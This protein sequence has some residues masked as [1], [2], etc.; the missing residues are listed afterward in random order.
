MGRH[1]VPHGGAPVVAIPTTAGT[2]SEMTKVAII[3]DEANDVK[4]MMFDVHLLPAVALVDYELTLS[5][6]PALT[7]AVGVD[8]L[9]HGIEALVSR[10]AEPSDRPVGA[11]VPRSGQ[12]DLQPV[13]GIR[14]SNF[15]LQCDRPGDRGGVRRAPRGRAP[16]RRVCVRHRIGRHH[17]GDR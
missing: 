17:R 12:R 1:Q 7:A 14:E 11:L 9:T 4:M 5:M 6:P 3:T 13:R 15:P 16:R 8:T 10:L 2:G